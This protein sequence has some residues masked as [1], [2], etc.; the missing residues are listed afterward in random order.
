PA[1]F[2]QRVSPT[3]LPLVLYAL[4]GIMPIALCLR[5]GLWWAGILGAIAMAVPLTLAWNARRTERADDEIPHADRYR[6]HSS[7]SAAT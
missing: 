6:V 2:A 3:R 5:H 7:R 4:N 1:E